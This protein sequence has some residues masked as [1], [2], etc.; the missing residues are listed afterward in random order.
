MNMDTIYNWNGFQKSKRIHFNLPHFFRLELHA[1]TLPLSIFIF[2]LP[3]FFF[4]LSFEG[5]SFPVVFTTTVL[6]FTAVG[7]VAGPKVMDNGR[8]L[9]QKIVEI[10]QKHQYL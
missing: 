8:K 7:S 4:R 10:W 2:L 3:S 1:K 9:K 5:T 6:N